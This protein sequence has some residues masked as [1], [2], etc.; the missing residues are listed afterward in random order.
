MRYQDRQSRRD[1]PVHKGQLKIRDKMVRISSHLLLDH[2]DGC[3]VD[4]WKCWM[5][6]EKI[7]PQEAV[8][9]RWGMVGESMARKK[10]SSTL[11]RQLHA[12]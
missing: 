7:D 1:R 2:V 8:F 4:W 12:S 6:E 3:N 10:V 11:A 5:K 9:E